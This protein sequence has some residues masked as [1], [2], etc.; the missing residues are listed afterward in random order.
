M[1]ESK[2]NPKTSRNVAAPTNLFFFNFSATGRL[3]FQEILEILEYSS[4]YR[5][6]I[7]RKLPVMMKMNSFL[8]CM[9]WG[10]IVIDGF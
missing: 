9:A 6:Q 8:L 10:S 1:L 4:E 7:N 2:S 5:A 3:K